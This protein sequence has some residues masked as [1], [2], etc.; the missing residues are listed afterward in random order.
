MLDANQAHSEEEI[1]TLLHN[2]RG[3]NLDATEQLFN[4]LYIQLSKISSALLSNENAVSLSTGDLVNEAA[5]RL[6]SLHKI[7]WQ[8]RVHF[9]A[10]S[11][12]VMRQVLI[13]HCRKKMAN[14]RQHERVTLLTQCEP[15]GE[16]SF[17]L[18]L[19]EESLQELQLIDPERV[20]IVEMRYYG[21]LS[22]T[23]IAA[24]KGVSAS[25]IKRSWRASRAW[26]LNSIESKQ[27]SN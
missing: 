17:D 4:K 3:G 9:L 1:I 8:D 2:W 18:D 11:A 10:L 21:G 25:T 24:V 27:L 19:L 26:L 12:K 5:I 7:D 13:D 6:I 15:Q 16:E 22:L 14:R 23:E 20:H